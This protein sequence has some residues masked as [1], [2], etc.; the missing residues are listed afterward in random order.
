MPLIPDVCG[1]FAS[2]ASIDVVAD[3]S[4]FLAKKKNAL[5]LVLHC[6]TVGPFVASRIKAS[7]YRL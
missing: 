7:L 6:V 2:D 5:C 4:F 3:V 1:S